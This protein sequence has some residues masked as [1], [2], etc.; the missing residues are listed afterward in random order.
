MAPLKPEWCARAPVNAVN[1]SFGV[2]KPLPARQQKENRY[3]PKTKSMVDCGRPKA[4]DAPRRKASRLRMLGVKPVQRGVNRPGQV[5]GRRAK[6][7]QAPRTHRPVQALRSVSAHAGE[8]RPVAPK[9][10]RKPPSV[11]AG[12]DVLGGG[13]DSWLDSLDPR[14]RDERGSLW[15]PS[16]ASVYGGASVM[17]ADEPA[18][19]APAPA[20]VVA[21][22]AYMKP[23]RPCPPVPAEPPKRKATPA[24]RRQKVTWETLQQ[25]FQ[26][27]STE[28]CMRACATNQEEDFG[29]A[30][31][32]IRP[33]TA[34]ND[35]EVR[36]GYGDSEDD[37]DNEE[38]IVVEAAAPP[39]FKA[40]RAMLVTG[41]PLGAAYDEDEEEEEDEDAA[42]PEEED[43][44]ASFEAKRRA[45]RTPP[46]PLGAAYDDEDET[47]D[48]ESEGEAP[49]D[50]FKAKRAMLV[51]GPPPLG[52]AYDED[53]TDEDDE[54]DE[55][56]AP[57]AEAPAAAAP[58]TYD[59]DEFDEA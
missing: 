35:E 50:S 47:D 9:R 23:R 24:A 7:V 46:P 17:T 15:D 28:E 30:D 6:S 29:G 21:P 57:V 45:L 16:R 51:T 44:D 20:P 39:N 25:D 37:D 11:N 18:V 2:P 22:V 26:P 36:G 59:D 43:D 4:M 1:K 41:P 52:A 32:W 27:P 58:G 42:A 56:E 33:P 40:K 3:K 19:E 13:C 14:G 48:D 54:D 49:I 55:A 53:E 31:V 5:H 12:R 34:F 10:E 38:G 8:K